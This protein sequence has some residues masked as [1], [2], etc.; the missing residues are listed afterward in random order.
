MKV[1]KIIIIIIIALVIT[2]GIT[3]GV[4]FLKNNKSKKVIDEPIVVN[5]EKKD[6]DTSGINVN[7]SEQNEIQSPINENGERVLV[8]T[9]TDP[10]LII[11]PD[12]THDELEIR[13]K[14]II[15]DE[16]DVFEV[17]D[18]EQSSSALKPS[19][20]DEGVNVPLLVLAGVLV[21]AFVGVFLYTNKIKNGKKI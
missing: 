4:E 14:A 7:N 16:S 12:D 21:I 8:N 19:S 9:E 18:N 17:I 11:V 20:S 15:E 1:K 3:F 5:I 6:N 10:A 13:V 2:A